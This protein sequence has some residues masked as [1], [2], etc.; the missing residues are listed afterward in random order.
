MLCMVVTLLAVPGGLMNGNWMNILIAAGIFIIGRS[1]LVF[2][3]KS[4]PQMSDVFRRSVRY[5]T[6]YPAV[7][8]AAF[9]MSAQDKR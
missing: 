1:L 6:E 8:T 4:D 7:S 5:R 2:M 9:R 3:A